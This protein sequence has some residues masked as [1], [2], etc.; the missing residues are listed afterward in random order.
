[1]AIAAASLLAGCATSGARAHSYV[2]VVTK[3]D[4]TTVCVGALAATGQCFIKDKATDAVRLNQCVRVSYSAKP[5]DSG[6]Y[7]ATRVTEV[8]AATHADCRDR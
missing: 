5:D 1:V 7:V 6:P 8:S 4:G 3:A 2:G